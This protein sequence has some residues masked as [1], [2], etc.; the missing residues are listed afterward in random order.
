MKKANAPVKCI[1]FTGAVFRK[2]RKI[3][4]HSCVPLKWVTQQ[5]LFTPF[6]R[7]CLL[8]CLSCLNKSEQHEMPQLSAYVL[9]E[10]VCMHTSHIPEHQILERHVPSLFYW[11]VIPEHT[12]GL[13]LNDVT[14]ELWNYPNHLPLWLEFKNKNKTTT[15]TTMIISE[16]SSENLQ[17]HRKLWM[18]TQSNQG[19]V[20]C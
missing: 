11:Y 16:L 17:N 10:R 12:S 15:T 6:C 1:H 13:W 5:F 3:Q 14:F 9:L 4:L 7:A 19:H 18:S 20:I 8:C 2:Y